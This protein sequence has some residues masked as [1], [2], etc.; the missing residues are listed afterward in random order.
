MKNA[1]SHGQRDKSYSNEKLQIICDFINDPEY[2]YEAVTGMTDQS[3]EVKY[4]QEVNLKDLNKSA[5]HQT[6]G[7]ESKDEESCENVEADLQ[8]QFQIPSIFNF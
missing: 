7:L 5:E 4:T 8:V 6:H 1:E 3:T 2:Q